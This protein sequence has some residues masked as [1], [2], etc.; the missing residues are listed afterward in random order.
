MGAWI[1]AIVPGPSRVVRNVHEARNVKTFDNDILGH[2]F[3][4][5]AN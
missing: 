3:T 1:L 4:Y 2:K 5:L